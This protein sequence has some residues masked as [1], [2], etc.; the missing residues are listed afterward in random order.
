MI[1]IRDVA[2]AANVSISTVSWVLNNN[3][4]V[5]REKRN[6]VMK[7]IDAVGYVPS[8]KSKDTTKGPQIILVI[9]TIFHSVLCPAIEESASELGYEVLFKYTGE[10]DGA[11]KGKTTGELYRNFFKTEEIAGILLLNPIMYKETYMDFL[12]SNYPVVQVGCSIKDYGGYS[13]SSD[14][15]Q[16]SY[17]M[18]LYLL[19][20]GYKKIALVTPDDQ[21]D[22]CHYS[23]ARERYYGYHSAMKN[24]GYEESDEQIIVCDFSVEG[25][26]AAAREIL[27]MDKSKR[28]DAVFCLA[29]K[30]ALGCMKYLT[31]AGKMHIPEDLGIAGFDGDFWGIELSP[32]LTTVSQAFDDIAAESVQMLDQLV[33]KDISNG[34]KLYVAHSIDVRESTK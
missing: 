5:T 21:M 34:R 1:T 19:S 10:F 4:N 33:R 32:S 3:P 16:A 24:S 2:K 23:F 15:F 9:T 7:A 14:D 11:I 26:K 17:D 29:D 27:S 30:M 25:G 12:F 8:I 31:S 6:R 13:V 28:P 18:T 20:R 22:S